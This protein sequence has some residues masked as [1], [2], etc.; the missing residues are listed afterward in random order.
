MYLA[1]V[2]SLY[3]FALRPIAVG[4]TFL[5]LVAACRLCLVLRQIKD[6]ARSAGKGRASSEDKS[7]VRSLATTL[8][9]VYGGEA[10]TAPLLGIPPSFIVSGIFPG[11]Y[12]CVQAIVDALPAVPAP[13]L[14]TEV[15][16]AVVDGFTR[17]F[18]LCS[19]VPPPVTT[20]ASPI[21]STSP[22]TLLVTSLVTSNGGFFLANLFSFIDPAP[23]AIA[24]PLELRPY[25]WTNIDLWCA[26]LITGIYALFTHAQPFWADAHVA[27]VGFMGTGAALREG[28]A[29]AVE[30]LDPDVVRAACA[31][32]LAGL[33]VNRTFENSR[34]WTPAKKAD[35][36]K[37]Q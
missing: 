27:V 16:L 31:V 4:V 18:L 22:W 6:M 32:I 1:P 33:F 24:T 17:A 9:V 20:N 14:Y 26:P 23:L 25:G 15:P 35:K 21:L 13:S 3:D 2:L 19:L 8:L 11:L 5:D 12:A 34:Q 10:M 7:F 36:A 29:K 30:A 28:G 37:T